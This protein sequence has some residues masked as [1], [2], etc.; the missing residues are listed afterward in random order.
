MPTQV[1]KKKKN[2]KNNKKHIKQVILLYL[3]GQQAVLNCEI[4]LQQKVVEILMLQVK[5]VRED[6]QF[7]REPAGGS[8]AEG[9]PPAQST[10]TCNT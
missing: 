9:R 4:L 2:P 5:E 8:K 6:L 3:K 1:C 10:L 7:N